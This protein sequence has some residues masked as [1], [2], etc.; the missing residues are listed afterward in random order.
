[1]LGNAPESGWRKRI[2]KHLHKT[3]ESFA[4]DL[5]RKGFDLSVKREE[6]DPEAVDD[7]E[8]PDEERIED[9]ADLIDRADDWPG[10]PKQLPLVIV[11]REGK[12]MKAVDGRHRI[13]AAIELGR[14]SIPALVVSSETIVYIWNNSR[15][16]PFEVFAVRSALMDKNNDLRIAG[17]ETRFS[18]A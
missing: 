7:I 2:P 17:G 16:N 11:A 6:I 5:E 18:W 13:H 1:M 3:Y 12:K 9:L 10:W 8:D 4:D 15:L 14:K